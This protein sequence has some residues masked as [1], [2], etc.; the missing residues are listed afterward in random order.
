MTFLPRDRAWHPPA[1]T[2]GYKSSIQRSP[3]QPLIA[4]D[5][6]PSET[7]GPTFGHGL[8]G[9]LDHDLIRNFAQGD[10]T[11][12]GQRLIVH[13]RALDDN[14]RGVPGA[15]VEIWQANAG[16]RYRHA[17]ETY[18]APLDPNFAGCGRTITGAD[19]SYRFHTVKPGAYPFPNGSNSWRPAHIHFSVFGAGLAQRLITQMYF[20]GDPMIRHCPIV[21]TL[22]SQ[23]AVDSL[24][25]LYDPDATLPM[26]SRAF[27]FD[28]VLRGRRETPFEGAG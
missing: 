3:R 21:A 26:D 20:E 4:F 10:A 6:T 2:P 18:L 15:L 28:I 24:I 12:I 16:G 7:T 25:A 11:P 5:P 1:L 14:G 27:R 19:G 13:G 8:T 22:P 17:K 9:D 23:E